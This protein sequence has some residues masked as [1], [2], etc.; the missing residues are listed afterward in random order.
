[1]PIF[2]S[3]GLLEALLFVIVPATSAIA[4]AQSPQS[5]TESGAISGIRENGVADLQR[6]SLC[7]P[8]GRRLALAASQRPFSH[9]GL[10]RVEGGGV[11][12]CVYANRCV[13][14]W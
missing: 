6:C 10:A 13:H 12:P 9:P 8:A 14:A 3:K 11:C 4:L 7:C 2:S 5:W 1:M